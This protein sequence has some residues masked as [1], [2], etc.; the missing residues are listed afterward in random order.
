[1]KWYNYTSQITR[2]F[3][4]ALHKEYVL[5]SYLVKLLPS[6]PAP[7]FGLNNRVKLEYYRLGKTYEGEIELGSQPGAWKATNPKKACTVP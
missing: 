3:D 1:M 6:D 5:C 2:M 4:K 7:E